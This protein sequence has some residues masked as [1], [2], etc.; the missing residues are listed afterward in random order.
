MAGGSTR[1]W[2]HFAMTCLRGAGHFASPSGSDVTQ[3][4]G[5]GQYGLEE[6]RKRVESL[7]SPVLDCVEIVLYCVVRI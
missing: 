1:A 2:V 5:A 7:E 4:C 6:V 3:L